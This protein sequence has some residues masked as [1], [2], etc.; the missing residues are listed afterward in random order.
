MPIHESVVCVT[1]ALV[2]LTMSRVFAIRVVCTLIRS[3]ALKKRKGECMMWSHLLQS[4]QNTMT[5][6]CKQANKFET[7]RR[8]KP[9]GRPHV[10][11]SHAKEESCVLV[12]RKI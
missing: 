11:K 5:F 1:S 4:Q 8:P 7:N 12:G 3:C 2:V 9:S 10:R 6:C